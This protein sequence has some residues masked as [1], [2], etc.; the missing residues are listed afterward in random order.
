MKRSENGTKVMLQKENDW[1]CQANMN[2]NGD[3]NV[4][5]IEDWGERKVEDVCAYGSAVALCL[6]IAA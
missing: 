5:E 1:L 3:V 4:N 2:L 6:L